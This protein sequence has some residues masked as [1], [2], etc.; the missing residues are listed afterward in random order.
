MYT[1]RT[2]FHDAVPYRKVFSTGQ[3]AR[4][5]RVAPRT[6]SKWIDSGRLKGY[7]IPGSNDRRVPRANLI[8]FLKE[9][10]LPLGAL[11]EG[12]R[13]LVVGAE[14]LLV[15]R[16]LGLLP[17]DEGYGVRPVGDGFDAGVAVAEYAPHAVVLDLV[18]GRNPALAIAAHV[19]AATPATL[20]A[21]LA[22]EDEADLAGLAAAFD[23][24]YQR[25]FDPGLLGEVIRAARDAEE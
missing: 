9:H 13:V 2:G 21:A 3:V 16:L 5:C 25:P 24:V 19:R 8:K 7:R 1:P 18:V 22:C 11:G 12:Y 23:H 4:V 17:Q 15:A 10:G 14:P 6:V 20:L